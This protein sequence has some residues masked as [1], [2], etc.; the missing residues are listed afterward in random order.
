MKPISTDKLKEISKKIRKHILK[1]IYDSQS[2]HIGAALSIVDILVILYFHTMNV[3]SK[4]YKDVLRDKFVLSKAHASSALY[5]TLVEKE[6]IPLDY[7]EKYCVDDGIL[8][9]HLDSTF[10]PGIEFSAGSLGHGLSVA[11]GMAIANLQL[12]HSGRIFTLVGD[13]ECNEGSIWEAIMLASHLK[14]SNLT[15][16]VDYNKFQSFGMTNDVINQES[17]VDRWKS[18]GWDVFEVNG[19]NFLE[20][21]DAFNEPQS[22]PKVII[23][24]TVKGKGVSFME[25]KFEWHYKSPNQE[26][27]DLA[28]RE[29]D[30]PN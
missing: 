11:V 2:S 1:M 29:M 14:L 17:I 8:P 15:A 27:Y 21:I 4:N 28:I 5:A 10:V 3:D 20:L 19:H 26:Q 25:N 18:F 7:L 22:K 23:A 24:H 9:G 13:G 30:D 6:I 16:I 12:P